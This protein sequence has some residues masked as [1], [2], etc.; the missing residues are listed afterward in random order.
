MIDKIKKK[1]K[2]KNWPSF[3]LE[4]PNKFDPF[5]ILPFSFCQIQKIIQKNS[6]FWITPFPF[7]GSALGSKEI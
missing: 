3:L 5:K 6:S 7:P 2:K 1:N 4:A